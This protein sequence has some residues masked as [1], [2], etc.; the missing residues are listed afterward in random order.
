MEPELPDY[1]PGQGHP[2]ETINL[3]LNNITDEQLL[4]MIEAIKGGCY[5][6]LEKL[7]LYSNRIGN[8]GCHAIATLLEDPNSNIQTLDLD[9]NQ[10]GTEGA[11]AIANSL[12]NNTNLETLYLRS[13]P[14]DPSVLGIFCRAL[15]NTSS[16]N[17]TY[18]SNHTLVNLLLSDEQQGQH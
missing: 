12:A 18:H 2:I 16:V 6:S 7:Y 13:N 15:C 3:A 11:T 8:A 4:P 10:I 17:D 5:T 9:E 14:F 1:S